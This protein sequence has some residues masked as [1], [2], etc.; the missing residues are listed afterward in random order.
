LLSLPGVLGVALALAVDAAAIQLLYRQP[1]R[2]T[3]L[4]TAIHAII[5]VILGTVVG[6]AVIL[7]MSA[8][9]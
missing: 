6:G 7:Y 9:G 4:I 3:G 2:T 8:P 5:T 1:R